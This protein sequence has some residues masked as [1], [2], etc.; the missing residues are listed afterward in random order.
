MFLIRAA[1]WL[2]VAILFIPADPE[3]GTV[4]EIQ[5]S[6]KRL[7]QRYAA[8]AAAQ[9]TAIA[10]AIRQSGAAHLRLRTDSDWLLDIV[11][12]VAASRR[13]VPCHR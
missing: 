8:A 6:D 7:R 11:R 12:F 4:H 2:S 5:T 3:T 10:T 9:R 1:F 13:A